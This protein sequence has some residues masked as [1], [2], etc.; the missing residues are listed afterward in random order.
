MK[1]AMLLLSL[2]V[3]QAISMV[4]TYLW[5]VVFEEFVILFKNPFLLLH[6]IAV[7]FLS[8]VIEDNTNAL[9]SIY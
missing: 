4:L 2:P 7:P 5:M 9:F 6:P 8:K 1:L 3:R